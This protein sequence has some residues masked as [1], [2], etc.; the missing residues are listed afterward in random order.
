MGGFPNLFQN[1]P[2]RDIADK[3]ANAE[4]CVLEAHHLLNAMRW[5]RFLEGKRKRESMM[6]D[7]GEAR[8]MDQVLKR[9]FSA[10]LRDAA[11]I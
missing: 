1:I 10:T 8:D 3:A 5:P 7:R 4:R 6:D 9:R 11:V 2:L